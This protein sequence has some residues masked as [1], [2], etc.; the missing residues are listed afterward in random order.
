MLLDAISIF[1]CYIKTSFVTFSIFPPPL[2]SKCWNGLPQLCSLPYYLN[3]FTLLC[4]LNLTSALPVLGN[5]FWDQVT[6]PGHFPGCFI[7]GNKR[8]RQSHVALQR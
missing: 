1:E 7:K 6:F 8:K 2:T 3:S 5:I 4:K